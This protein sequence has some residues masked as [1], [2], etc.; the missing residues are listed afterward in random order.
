MKKSMFRS[1]MALF[2]CLCITLSLA[3]PALAASGWNPGGTDHNEGIIG[4]DGE[5]KTITLTYVKNSYSAT[6]SMEPQTAEVKDGESA[7]FNIQ[8]C[9]FT[10]GTREFQGW[11]VIPAGAPV[12]V[13]SNPDGHQSTT[14]TISEDTTLYAL[15]TGLDLGG[16]GTGEVEVTPRYDLNV[17]KK[18][19]S[20]AENVKSGDVVEYTVTIKNSSNTTVYGLWV[21]DTMQTGLKIYGGSVNYTHQDAEGNTKASGSG[22]WMY[23]GTR[24][25]NSMTWKTTMSGINLAMGDILTLTYKVQVTNEGEEAI[26]LKNSAVAKGQE[27]ESGSNVVASSSSDVSVTVNPVVTWTVTF[28]NNTTGSFGQSEYFKLVETKEVLN[29]NT[30][31]PP[32]VSNEDRPDY[33][34][35]GWY[36]VGNDGSYSWGDKYNFSTPVTSD[37]ILAAEWEKSFGT[38]GK[39][40]GQL[41]DDISVVVTCDDHGTETY[42]LTDNDF[43]TARQTRASSDGSGEAKLTV[44]VA[45]YVE[46]YGIDNGEHRLVNPDKIEIS[47][48]KAA[49]STQWELAEGQDGTATISVKCVTHDVTFNPNGGELA[50]GTEA[51]QTVKD[52]EKVK[53]PDAPTA[54]DGYEFDGWYNGDEKW[55][56]DEDT[57]TENVE[58]TAHWV[59]KSEEPKT[60]SGCNCGNEGC[61]CEGNCD[62][63]EGCDC[64]KCDPD[65]GG[66]GDETDPKPEPTPD[67]EPTPVPSDVY[68]TLVYNMNNGTGMTTSTTQANNPSFTVQANS[69][70][71][72]GYTFEGWATSADGAVEYLPGSRITISGT[73]QVLYAVWSEVSVEIPEEDPPLSDTPDVEIPEED[74]PLSDTPD[75]EIPEEDPPLSDTPDVEIPEED[76]PLSDLPELDIPDGDV[77]LAGVPDT[78]DYSHIWGVVALISGMGLA[79]LVLTNK[80]REEI[81]E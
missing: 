46:H 11:A 59:E 24:T 21:E 8:E 19:T 77:P 1:V 76:P 63:E 13:P 79:L 74:P 69:F 40:K 67:P 3:V 48:V 31:T 49:G 65:K 15:W 78:G 37:L 27:S 32:V 16:G 30:V 12:Y 52:G 56:F 81:A 51:T 23:G 68:Y 58:L 29:G 18:I 75:V 42:K 44:N 47:L 60:D 25:E 2:L 64:E 35:D 26:V 28:Y 55:D 9:G 34:F 80:K 33:T 50:K 61:K 66:N 54:P 5:T 62:C 4:G 7:T 38:S 36:I 6:G 45:K 53:E 39:F 17:T 41:P 71:R 70:T 14:I 72:E 20:N 43:Y 57:V 73:S 10:N 22:G